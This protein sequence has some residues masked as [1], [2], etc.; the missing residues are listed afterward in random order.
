M[1]RRDEKRMMKRG[2]KKSLP[3]RL[4]KL[5]VTS[6]AKGPARHRTEWSR[7]QKGKENM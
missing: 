7:L 3:S 2:R 6:L 1:R 5:A 4:M